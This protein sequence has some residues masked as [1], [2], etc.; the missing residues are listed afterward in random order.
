MLR[1]TA[2]RIGDQITSKI[3]RTR[4]VM[5]LAPDGGDWSPFLWDWYM[6]R[7]R[8]EEPL[9]TTIAIIPSSAVERM[10]RVGPSFRELPERIRFKLDGLIVLTRTKFVNALLDMADCPH[11]LLIVHAIR[12]ADII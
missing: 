2:Y 4:K 5:L 9:P 6:R 10:D 8:M 11:I 1:D 3:R 12:L 7:V